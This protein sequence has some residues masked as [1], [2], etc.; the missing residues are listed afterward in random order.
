MQIAGENSDLSLTTE[1]VY[2]EGEFSPNLHHF[3]LSPSV[4]ILKRPCLVESDSGVKNMK[5]IL[6]KTV[7]KWFISSQTEQR[8]SS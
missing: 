5:K 1:G 8:H 6:L 4:T 3:V 7:N 2:R